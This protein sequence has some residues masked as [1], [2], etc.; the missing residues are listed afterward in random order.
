MDYEKEHFLNRKSNRTTFTSLLT[1]N[2]SL[3]CVQ[4][5]C[6]LPLPPASFE[7]PLHTTELNRRHTRAGHGARF[8]FIKTK[9]PQLQNSAIPNSTVKRMLTVLRLFGSFSGAG[10][11]SRKTILFHVSRPHYTKVSGLSMRQLFSIVTP[12]R[13]F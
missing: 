4:V 3:G 12:G 9:Q 5:Q 1:R 11:K 8:T 2:S 7:H 6:R 13:I 10:G